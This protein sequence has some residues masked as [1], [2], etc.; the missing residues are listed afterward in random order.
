MLLFYIYKR[1][2]SMCTINKIRPM[3]THLI[4][5]LSFTQIYNDIYIY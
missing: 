2:I 5:S 3:N 4:F 1:E